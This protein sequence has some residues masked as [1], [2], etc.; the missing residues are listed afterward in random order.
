MPS[1]TRALLATAMVM[2]AGCY[3]DPVDFT[4][5]EPGEYKGGEVVALNSEQESELAKRFER[6]GD[7]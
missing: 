7:R 4:L 5:H 1:M 6:Q 2:I 3:D